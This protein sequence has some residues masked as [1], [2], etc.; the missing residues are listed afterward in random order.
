LDSK[1][2]EQPTNFIK[3]RFDT[4]EDYMLKSEEA[5]TQED[6][7]FEV[8]KKEEFIQPPVVP[9]SVPLVPIPVASSGSKTPVT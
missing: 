3:K 1:Q 2:P 8:I 4:V 5:S 6:E 9:V 7:G